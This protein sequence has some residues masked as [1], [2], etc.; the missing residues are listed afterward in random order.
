MQYRVLGRTGLRVSE[1]SLGTWAMGGPAEI[2]GKQIG[3]GAADDAGSLSALHRAQELGVNF[4]DT[5]DVYGFGHSEELLG[6]AFGGHWDGCY[7]A[8]K[9]GN[10]RAPGG[11]TQKNFSKGY[12]LHA[13]EASL[14]RLRKDTIDLYQLH[15]PS[16]DVIQ[17]G[18]WPE[19]MEELVHA[20]KVCFYG[21]SITTREEARAFLER[22]AGHT[23]QLVYN[24]VRQEMA[25]LFAELASANIAV[26]VRVP[27]YY[28]LLTG[29]FTPETRFPA[30]DHRAERLPPDVLAA[31]LR[32]IEKLKFLVQGS[33]TLAQAALKFILS[34]PAVSTVIPGGRSVRQVEDNCAASDGE[35]L[36]REELDRIQALWASGFEA[37][38]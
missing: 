20:G 18:D 25:E 7:V 2:D 38:W 8:T 5:A 11:L 22:G 13:C 15:N 16:L 36:T 21:V 4:F 1:I 14:H 37:S 6:Q 17:Q 31:E 28:G 10:V 9:V 34:H 29:K 19:V 12:I 33:R 32:K 24:L 26:I 23:I 35:L 27:L 30:D 3:W